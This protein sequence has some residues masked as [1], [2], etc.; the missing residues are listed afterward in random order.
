MRRSP[1]PERGRIKAVTRAAATLSAV[2]LLSGGLAACGK[3]GPGDTLNDFL[4]AWR[5]RGLRGEHLPQPGK[6]HFSAIDGFLDASSPLCR[7]ILEQMA[8]Q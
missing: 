4:T 3:D 1:Q 7:A 6:D 2:V 8:V 5:S